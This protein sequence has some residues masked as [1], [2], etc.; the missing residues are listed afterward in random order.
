[1]VCH[2]TSI[3]KSLYNLLV[4]FSG[5]LPRRVSDSCTVQMICPYDS[6]GVL[7]LDMPLVQMA[8]LP[9]C[10]GCLVFELCMHSG[11]GQAGSNAKSSERYVL[12][13]CCKKQDAA[14]RVVIDFLKEVCA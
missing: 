10:G 13:L 6:K 9:A 7:V 11:S 2:H 12:M 4:Y 14:L 8:M 3:G 5:S 1:M